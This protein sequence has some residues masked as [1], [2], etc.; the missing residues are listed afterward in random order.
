MSARNERLKLR[1]TFWNSLAIA[2]AVGGVL[3]PII[4]AYRSDEI[5]YSTV[6]PVF[7][8]TAYRTFCSI[9]AGFVIAFILRMVANSVIG[10]IDD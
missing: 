3:V 7:S 1:A 2:A 9:G 8:A 5:W 6:Y 10:Q 4:E